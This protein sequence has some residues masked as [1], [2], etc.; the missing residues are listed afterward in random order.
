MSTIARMKFVNMLPAA[1]GLRATL[2]A[3]VQTTVVDDLVA[4]FP[5]VARADAEDQVHA[6]A[7]PLQFARLAVAAFEHVFARRGRFPRGAH[8]EQ[9]HEVVVGQRARTPREDAALRVVDKIRKA[10]GTASAIRGDMSL[11]GPRPEVEQFVKAF[12]DEYAEILTVKPG[13]T[14]Q[15]T[16]PNCRSSVSSQ[17]ASIASISSSSA[18]MT[19][20]SSERDSSR[21]AS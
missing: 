2:V 10:G 8:V 18:L 1:P 13:I 15:G 7:G 14:H 11:V 4:W 3:E 5:G 6:G 9:V 19:L 12:P 16:L 21:S 17:P 20:R